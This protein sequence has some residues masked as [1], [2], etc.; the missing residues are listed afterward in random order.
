MSAAAPE[1]SA[2]ASI[3]GRRPSAVGQRARGLLHA[4][5]A[6][7]D[8][9]SLACFR[10]AFGAVMVWEVYRYFTKGWITSYYIRPWRSMPHEQ[11]DADE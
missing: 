3:E 2:P 5:F 7:V 11:P 1:T 4:A 8:I 6:P 9:A 10:V